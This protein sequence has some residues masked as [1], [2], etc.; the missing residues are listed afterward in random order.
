LRTNRET[1]PEGFH[2]EVLSDHTKR[3]REASQQ[4]NDPQSLPAHE[5]AR[6]RTE[7]GWPGFTRMDDH[8]L[9]WFTLGWRCT[10]KRPVDLGEADPRSYI[11]LAARL[12]RQILDGEVAPGQPVPSITALS[13]ELVHA[14]QTC[15]KAMQLLEQEELL[16]FI[17]GLGY[18]AK[19]AEAPSNGT[20]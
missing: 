11:R 5:V 16:T 7:V 4:V 9:V 12:R 3:N 13:Q 15:S 20:P 14:R 8:G 6:V 10:M 19:A 2:D 1:T 17:P 18:Y